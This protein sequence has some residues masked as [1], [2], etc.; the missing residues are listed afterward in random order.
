MEEAKLQ[1]WTWDWY[2]PLWGLS[3]QKELPGVME[4]FYIFNAVV[5]HVCTHLSKLTQLYI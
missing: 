4:M 1:W 5:L 2:L 3:G